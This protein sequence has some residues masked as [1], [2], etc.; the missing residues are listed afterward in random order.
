M[1][2]TDCFADLIAYVAYFLKT[3]DSQ[4][5]PFDQVKSDIRRLVSESQKFSQDNS[6]NPDEYNLARFAIFAWIDEAI[7]SSSWKEKSFWQGEQLQRHYY[8]TS[9]AGEEFFDYL[10]ALGPHQRDA[11]EVYYLCLAM[12]FEGRY[13]H[14]GDEYLLTQLKESNLKVLTGSSMGIYSIGKGDLFPEAYPA[15]SS[16]ALPWRPKRRFSLFTPLCLGVPV[17]LFFVLLGI[18]KFII[19]N[20]ANNLLTTVR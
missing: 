8:Q 16:E 12:G 6:V 18:Y 1:R 7:L 10:N 5:P 9:D 11:R 17:A 2:L 3:V 13:C 14:E 4:Q 20:I 15:D 19:S